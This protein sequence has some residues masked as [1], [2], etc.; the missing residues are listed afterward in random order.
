MAS[1]FED[2][3]KPNGI[4]NTGYSSE[5]EHAEPSKA[6]NDLSSPDQESEIDVRN[7]LLKSQPKVF[8]SYSVCLSFSLSFSHSFILSLSLTCFVYL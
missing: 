3:F 8:L 5:N 1:F 6:S 2:K 4:S 7:I